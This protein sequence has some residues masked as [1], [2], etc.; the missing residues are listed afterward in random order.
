MD[1]EVICLTVCS[2]HNFSDIN[3]FCDVFWIG[4]NAVRVE[5]PLTIITSSGKRN[6]TVWRPSVRLS[7]CPVVFLILIERA[8]RILTVTH[9][10]GEAR[11]RRGQRTF[12]SEW[13]VRGRTS[14]TCCARCR[15]NRDEK[16]KLEFDWSDK[17][18]ADELDTK[19]AI[20]R[21]E[22]TN[23]QFYPGAARFQEMYVQIILDWP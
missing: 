5:L 3:L 21:N 4:L 1:R 17:K 13:V 11:S 19:C 2:V 10:R 6:L 8:R 18:E 12:S 22:D 14:A 20:L 23:K 9:Q 15:R 16:K 7:V